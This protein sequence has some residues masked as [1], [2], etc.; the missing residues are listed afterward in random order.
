MPLSGVLTVNAVAY[1]ASARSAARVRLVALNRSIDGYDTLEFVQAARGA[2]PLWSRGMPVSLTTDTG[3]GAVLRFS[4][5][6]TDIGWQQGATG[7][8]LSYTAQGLRYQA[9]QVPVSASDGT[10]TIVYNRQPNDLYYLASESGLDV[11]TI[12]ARVL[13]VQET[14]DALDALGVGGYTSLSP[15]T[16]P[17]ATTASF[18]LLTVVPPS[19]CRL[20]GP[21]LSAL[22]QFA[23]RW[24]PKYVLELRPDGVLVAKDTTDTAVFVPA[25]VTLGSNSGV[26]TPG[27]H[28]PSVRSSTSRCYTRVLVR[29]GPEVEAMLLS[30]ADGTL[31]RGWTGGQESAWTLYDFTQP[32]GFVST[33]AITGIT[34][35]TATIDPTDALAAWAINYWSNAEA[36]VYMTDSTAAGISQ[37]QQRHVTANSAVSA[38]GTGTVTWDASW[39]VDSTTYDT[40]RLVGRATGNVDVGRLYLV[41]EPSTGDTGL[42]TYI[43]AHLVK[44]SA[45]AVRWANNEKTLELYYTT[46]AVE[47]GS[48]PV[49][50]PA[51]VEPVPSLG[52]FRFVQP[53]PTYFGN[54]TTLNTGWPADVAH[55]LPIDVQVLALYSR[56]ALSVAVP[57]DIAGVPQYEGTAFTADGV[58]ETFPLEVPTWIWKNDLA[59]MTTLGQEHLDSFK[60]VVYEGSQTYSVLPAWDFLSFGT[61]LNIAISGLTSPWSAMN[62]PIRSVR[63]EWCGPGTGSPHRVT[64]SFS[65]RRKAFTADEL[66]IPAAFATGSPLS[67]IGQ[68]S[69]NQGNYQQWGAT[70]RAGL[71]DTSFAGNRAIASAM[72]D[73]SLASIPTSLRDLG[74]PTS[75]SD[76]GLPTTPGQLGI[77]TS[78][79]QVLGPGAMSGIIDAGMDVG[80]GIQDRGTQPGRGPTPD[81]TGFQG[82]REDRL[83]LQ[84]ARADRLQRENLDIAEGE[85]RKAARPWQHEAGKYEASQAAME[86]MD[87]EIADRQSAGR[88]MV[89]RIDEGVAEREAIDA[90]N[91]RLSGEGGMGPPEA[92]AVQRAVEQQEGE[93]MMDRIDR[94]RERRQNEAGE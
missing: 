19:P 12:L 37:S 36:D 30:T 66:Y 24:H 2:V 69:P 67:H 81:I 18:A 85:R 26:G 52:G 50:E 53:T 91:N 56:G 34:G 92:E 44:R 22:E 40:Y 75:V 41:R 5:V 61:S 45:K 35:N 20:T 11:G 84:Q 71:V 42:S 62:A 59:A 64:V 13:T 23:T 87:R 3:G 80:A 55:G 65:T 39:P 28:W 74:I 38:G 4:G 94:E 15:P 10:G 72:P 60:D 76:L 32:K 63:L 7:W 88:A 77:P 6:I 17:A 54:P 73:N 33:G 1:G 79:G 47:G 25:T 83:A 78:M 31:V 93:T 46:G 90:R 68:D 48:V 21:V 70:V 58:E 16:L 51:D 29:G 57:A 14:A 9:D 8:A 49:T 43:G 89:E 27:A 86:R 82:T